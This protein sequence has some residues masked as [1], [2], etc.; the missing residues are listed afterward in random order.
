M[1]KDS[2]QKLL[3]R[4]ER[5]WLSLRKQLYVEPCCMHWRTKLSK[6][7]AALPVY[8]SA[9]MWSSRTPQKCLPKMFL[10]GV[11]IPPIHFL[12]LPEPQ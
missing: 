3:L 8:T 5:R 7:H 11:N 9:W 10:E 4:R 12:V 2:D 1:A 6:C